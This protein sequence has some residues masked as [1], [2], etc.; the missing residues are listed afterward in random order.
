MNNNP[1][2]TSLPI[3]NAYAQFLEQLTNEEFWHLAKESAHPVSF[4]EPLA[5]D[6]LCCTLK[7]GRCLLPLKLLREVVSPPY[8][9]TP[10]PATP[11]WMLGVSAWHGEI[12]AVID[13]DAYLCN[14]TTSITTGRTDRM[15]GIVLIMHCDNLILA[16]FVSSVE[17]TTALEPEQVIP[18]AQT[19]QQHTYTRTDILKGVKQ[20]TEEQGSDVCMPDIPALFTDIVQHLAK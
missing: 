5:A 11:P 1:G 12:V 9:F 2:F 18:F 19:T 13:L 17:T 15:N 14:S 10:L 4:G 20:A 7:H 16:L 6:Y 8:H 3:S